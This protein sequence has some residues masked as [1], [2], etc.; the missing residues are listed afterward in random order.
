MRTVA[1][2]VV[3]LGMI[4][5]GGAAEPAADPF[6]YFA[7]ITVTAAER[8]R[9]DQGQAA[10][11]IL[12]GRDREVVVFAAARTTIDADRLIAWVHDIA[13]LKKSHLVPLIQRFSNPPVA[14]DLANATLPDDDLDDLRGC[15]PGDCGVKVTAAE[16]ARLKP[17]LGPR[18]PGR[19]ARVRQAFRDIMLDRIRTYLAQGAAPLGTYADGSSPVSLQAAFDALLNRSPYIAT[20]LPQLASHF[21]QAPAAATRDVE[22]FLYWS[23]DL[24]R[25]LPVLTATHV[26]IVRGQAPAPLALVAGRQI[27]ATHYMN[28]SLSTTAVVAGDAGVRYLVYINRTDVDVVSGFFGP[29]ARRLIEG[30]IRSEAVTAITDLRKR[31]ESGPPPGATTR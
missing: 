5:G 6:E 27:F 15:D 4:A 9:L 19:D 2:L 11:R 14:T 31:L 16:L 22:W 8:R 20:R 21:R 30:R 7:P 29:L 25:S 23:Q 28:A 3:A 26:G 24:V 18:D 1:T 13:A 10:V 12:P 17:L